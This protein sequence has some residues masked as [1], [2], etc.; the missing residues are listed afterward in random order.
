MNSLDSLAIRTALISA[1]LA[2]PAA[3]FSQ[4]PAATPAAP[5]RTPPAPLL[6]P[7]PTYE[8]LVLEVAVNKPASQAWAKVGK[9]C[10]IEA[11]LGVKCL[12]VAG[13]DGEIGAVRTLNGGVIETLVGKTDLSYTYSQPV[14]VGQPYNNYHGTLEAKPVTATTSKLVYTFLY[15]T[16]MLDAAGKASAKPRREAQFNPALQKMKAIAEAG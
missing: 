9:F 6:V 1:L 3:A 7:E 16:S 14:R 15:D 4:A 12:I 8:T 2:A 5:A 10:D 13:K 11:W